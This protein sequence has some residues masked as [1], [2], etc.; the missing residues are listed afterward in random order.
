[1]G[2]RRSTTP[3]DTTSATS[4]CRSPRRACAACLRPEDTLAR[5][6]GDEFG[7]LL[8]DTDREGASEVAGRL[9][10]ALGDTVITVH[11]V[12]IGASIGITTGEVDDDVDD[13]LREADSSMYSVKANGGGAW[14]VF[15]PEDRRSDVRKKPLRTELQRAIQR[16][17]FIVHYQPIVRFETGAI[18]AVEAL[19]RWQHPERG[20]LAP[21]E[22]LDQAEETGQILFIDNWVMHE[23]CRQVKTWQTDIPGAAELSVCVNLSPSQLRHPGLAGSV[24]EALRV[25]GLRPQHLVVELTE[26]SLVRDLQAA[27]TELETLDALG[28]RLALDDFGTGYS[29]MSHLVRFPV[30]IIKIDRSF[31]SAMSTGGQGSDVAAAIIALGRALGLRVIGEGIEEPQQVDLLRSLGCEVGQGYHFAKPMDAAALGALM[32]RGVSL[33]LV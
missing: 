15:D 13:L 9:V 7:V 33:G 27:A 30:D 14:R 18:E 12:S 29:S 26:G 5:L 23:A 25:A 32:R 1:M 20:L 21:S 31:V 22:F 11:G 10:H 8:E 16:H 3:A 17:E 4:C 6:G 19:V 28:V 2:S 24:A